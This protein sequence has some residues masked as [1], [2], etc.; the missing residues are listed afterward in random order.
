MPVSSELSNC[1]TLLIHLCPGRKHQIAVS[2][3]EKRVL[4]QLYGQRCILCWT[5][6]LAGVKEMSGEM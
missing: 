4:V 3:E 6:A 2:R 5:I 1:S